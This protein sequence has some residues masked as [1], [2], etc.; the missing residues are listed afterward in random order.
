MSAEFA[1]YRHYSHG[2]DLRFIDWNIY[3]R[4]D[5]LFLKMFLEEEKAK[6]DS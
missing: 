6:G 4:L 3:A 5:R 1:D 2:D